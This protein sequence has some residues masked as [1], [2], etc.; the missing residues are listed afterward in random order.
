MKSHFEVSEKLFELYHRVHKLINESMTEE[1]VSL[2]RSKF[3]FFLSKLGPCRSTDI[4]DALSFAPRTVTEAIDG[5]ERDKLVERKPDPADRRAKI[6]SITQTGRQ[7][8]EAAE[9]PRKQV[10][11]EIFSALDDQ[12]LDQLQSIVNSL[13][14]KADDIRLRR[15]DEKKH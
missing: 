15:E 2:A 12:Q 8:L 6:V 10:L 7:V 13:V 3:L 5:L 9:T 14:R 4:A 1:G 11:E